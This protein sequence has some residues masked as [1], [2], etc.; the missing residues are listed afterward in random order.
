[1]E[2]DGEKKYRDY[3]QKQF[4]HCHDTPAKNLAA[5]V[6]GIG[7]TSLYRFLKST[8]KQAASAIA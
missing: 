3:T 6:L 1:V 4:K 5:R 7:R 2:Q 8:G